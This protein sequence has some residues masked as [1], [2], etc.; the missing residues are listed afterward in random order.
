MKLWDKY[1]KKD[2]KGQLLQ[3]KG[4]L[5]LKEGADEAAFQKEMKEYWDVS[6]TIDWHKLKLEDLEVVK[7]PSLTPDEIMAIEPLVFHLE[8]VKG[9]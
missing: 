5:V 1:C 2:D 6:F 3:D 7:T 8:E 9:V 4:S